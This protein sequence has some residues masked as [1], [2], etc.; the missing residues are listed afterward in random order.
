MPNIEELLRKAM[1]EGKFDNL[2]GKGQPLH[3]DKINPHADPDWELAYRMLKEAGYSL[4]WIENLR[5][6]EADLTAA[7]QD[8][9]LAWQVFRQDYAQQGATSFLAESW[10]RSQRA[11]REKLA[12]LNKR[13]RD[14]NLTVPAARFQRP[15]LDFEGEVN[16]V[17]GQKE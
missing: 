15:V 9:Q 5:A 11:F 12:S 8:L 14:Y 16:K 13:I 4:P 6:V 2:P 1:E 17:K 10:E 3:L 7:R